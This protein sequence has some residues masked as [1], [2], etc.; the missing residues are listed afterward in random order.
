MLFRSNT[1][2]LINY[3]PINPT[4]YVNG[5]TTC[6]VQNIQAAI[7]LYKNSNLVNNFN[8][9]IFDTPLDLNET[10]VRVYVNNVRS[11]NWQI[12]QVISESH[13]SYSQVVF[14]SNLTT[15]DI[16]LIKVFTSTPIS[17]PGVGY[18]E[19]PLSLQNNP[20]NGS[21]TEFTL[22]EVNDHVHSIVENIYLELD[23]KL[24]LAPE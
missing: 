20:P 14:N 13:K 6:K 17:T 1:G 7:R 12:K 3:D 11:T 23:I 4:Q 19:I 8:I 15:D 24:G 10:E 9:D 2:F 21:I 22:G 5:W 18:Y 16:V